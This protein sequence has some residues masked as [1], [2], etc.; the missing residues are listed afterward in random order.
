MALLQ[1]T[2]AGFL[3]TALD[4]A[5][6]VDADIT[7]LDIPTR[8][9]QAFGAYFKDANAG[10]PVLAPAIDET[11]VPAMAAAMT[12][13]TVGTPASGAAVFTAGYTA[14]WTAMV[15]AP[16]SFFAGATVI[17][18]ATGLA[19]LATAVA[20]IFPLNNLPDITTAQAAANLA[21]A[22]HP[23]AGLTGTATFGVPTVAII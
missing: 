5:L 8:I 23:N 15:G 22:I 6:P 19:A 20:A 4:P 10:T 17:T 13:P 21:T 12:F 1:A 11:A 14:F 7:S 16:V 2:L 9:A 3:T 18:P